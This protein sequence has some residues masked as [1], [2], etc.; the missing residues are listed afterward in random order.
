[1][2]RPIYQIAEDIRQDWKKP[3][4]GAIPY[5]E[6]MMS[7]DKVTDRYGYDDGYDIVLYFLGNATSW[8]GEKARAIKAELK[9]IVKEA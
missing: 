4:F 5:L 6:A 8:R 3:Y 2:S 9:E 7:L 1:M